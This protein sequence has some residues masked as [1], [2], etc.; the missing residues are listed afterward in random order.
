MARLKLSSVD[1]LKGTKAFKLQDGKFGNKIKH[2][3]KVPLD[4]VLHRVKNKSVSKGQCLIT[5]KY[6]L[7]HRS[8]KLGKIEKMLKETTVC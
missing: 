2:I 5:S 8:E 1:R 3:L 7:K 6:F 4:Q